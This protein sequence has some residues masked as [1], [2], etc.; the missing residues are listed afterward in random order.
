MLL[1][2]RR[3]TQVAV[4]A[5]KP[6]PGYRTVVKYH[7]LEPEEFIEDRHGSREIF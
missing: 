1:A 7:A 3:Y 2:E 5:A 4:R 6:L